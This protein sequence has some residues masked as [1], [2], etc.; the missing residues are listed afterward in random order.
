MNRCRFT[1]TL[2]LASLAMTAWLSV[3]PA[4]A[5]TTPTRIT[6]PWDWHISVSPNI[7]GGPGTPPIP[8]L[9]TPIWLW[10][11]ATI[12]FGQPVLVG[13]QPGATT[14]PATFD[15][16][17]GGGIGAPTA[18][19]VPLGGIYQI[20]IELVQMELHSMMPAEFPMGLSDVIIRN[21]PNQPSQGMLT[22][23]SSNPDGSIN[24]NSFF[25]V[26]TEI[27]LPN[28]GMELQ[29]GPVDIGMNFGITAQPNPNFGPP[30]PPLPRLDILWAPTW[31]WR[32]F[33]PGQSPPWVTSEFHPWDWWVTIHGH[34]TVPE[35][36]SLLLLAMSGMGLTLIKRR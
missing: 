14:A 35:P 27:S 7:G 13:L 15:L 24:V 33:P 36:Q 30:A 25:D 32:T 16:G 6:F 8:G 4:V 29:S 19:P 11:T 22:E 10:G 23:V 26:F 21:N 20:P 2:V 31:I 9:P 28:L 1:L 17:P 34:V 5:Q 3:N 18:E 12:D